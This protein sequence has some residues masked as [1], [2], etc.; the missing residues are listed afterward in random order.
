[1]LEKRSDPLS[2]TGLLLAA[3]AAV[4]T[5]AVACQPTYSCTLLRVGPQLWL[6]HSAPVQIPYTVDLEF[7]GWRLSALCGGPSADDGLPGPPLEYSET[8][9]PGIDAGAPAA[10]QFRCDE[11]AMVLSEATPASLSVSLNGSEPTAVTPDYRQYDVNGPGC[12]GSV[13]GEAGLGFELDPCRRAKRPLEACATG[14][15][16]PAETSVDCRVGPVCGSDGRLYGDLCDLHATA[17]DETCVAADPVGC[18]GI[19]A[20]SVTPLSI[21]AE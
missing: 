20:E 5:A 9:P 12:G 13:V 10:F 18:C 4:A 14:V 3:L 8:G 1:M 17:G 6:H 16:D 21:E 7:D 19:A 2:T 15:A 11:L